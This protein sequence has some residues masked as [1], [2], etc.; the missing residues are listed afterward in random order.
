M[1]WFF[2]FACRVWGSASWKGYKRVKQYYSWGQNVHQ[3][4]PVLN[5][6][7]IGISILHNLPHSSGFWRGRKRQW[8][9]KCFW[10]P[11]KEE[12]SCWDDSAFFFGKNLLSD[13]C[14]ALLRVSK[15]EKSENYFFLYVSGGQNRK[16][17]KINGKKVTG[18]LCETANMQVYEDSWGIMQEVWK[19]SSENR[20]TMI[21]LKGIAEQ[22]EHHK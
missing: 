9:I 6:F 22:K 10:T 14:R 19:K 1:W 5:A 7:I 17:E 8:L 16:W 20:A 15:V 13:F 3:R 21:N 18:R 4:D 12:S 11:K 2:W